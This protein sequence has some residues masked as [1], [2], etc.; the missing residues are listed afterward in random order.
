MPYTAHSS[1]AIDHTK[2]GASDS[3]NFPVLVSGVY[4]FLATVAHGG[5][6]TSASGYDIVFT[7]DAL[8]ATLL[9]WEIDSYDPVTGT[10]NFWVKIPTLSH[11]VDTV[12][13]MWYGNA[14]ITTFQGGAA[15]VFWDSN[16]NPVYHFKDGTT[17]SAAD[18]TSHANN[19]TPSST[20]GSDAP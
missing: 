5:M 17:L 13:Y 19:C 9:N 3:A 4:A 8:G 7:S 11:T 12:I 1:L 18:S 15:G 20:V 16:F 10:V 14:A 6:V 2:A